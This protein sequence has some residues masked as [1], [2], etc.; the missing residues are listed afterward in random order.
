MSSNRVT[1]MLDKEI[2]KKLRQLQASRIA[3][4]NSS[5]SFS[6]V[7]NDA[8]RAHFKKRK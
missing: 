1:I 3:K 4:E 6:K 2:D 7:L 5:I 8:L